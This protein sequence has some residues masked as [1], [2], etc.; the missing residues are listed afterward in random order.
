MSIKNKMTLNITVVTNRNIYQCADYRLF[1][2]V[3]GRVSDI[4][5]QKIF[6]VNAYRWN[7]TVCFTGV[8][9]TGQLNV[10][11]WLLGVLSDIHPRESFQHL[12]DQLLLADE[13]LSKIPSTERRH[14]FN[15][16]A[17]VGSK[18]MFVLISN[19]EQPSGIMSDFASSRLAV[20]KLRPN[21][22]KVYLS[23]QRHN[24][25]RSDKTRLIK[26]ALTEPDSEKM[27]DALA[28]V[29]RSVARRTPYVSAACFTSH[30]HLTGEGGGRVHGIVNA[31]FEIP[32]APYGE[33]IKEAITQNLD[34]HFGIGKYRFN[35]FIAIRGEASDEFHEVQ[36][37]EKPDNP[38]VHTNF[39]NY[40]LEKKKDILGAEREYRQAIELNSQYVNALGNLAN[41]LWQH[42]GKLDEAETLYQRA[43][44]EDPGN[45][46]VSWNYVRFL[47]RENSH[48][49][50]AY[51]IATQGIKK[52][53][54]SGRLYLLRGEL[55]LLANNPAEAL[56]DFIVA[57]EKQADQASVEA[58]YAFAL[59]MSG[60]SF[61]ECI[62]AY[63]TAII[64]NPQN[65]ELRLNLAQLLYLK[66]NNN[67]A[68]KLLQEALSLGIT[69][70]A[71]LEAQFYLL[72]HTEG[73]SESIFQRIRYLLDEGAR[74]RWDIQPNVE[75]VA[76]QNKV[77]GALLTFVSNVISGNQDQK[78]LDQVLTSWGDW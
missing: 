20:Y 28:E 75:M 61:D 13:W 43:I 42:K 39:G 34:E 16:G 54:D 57:R 21:K 59:H 7:A 9:R 18:P 5:T 32:V 55:S 35:S 4:E 1:D 78:V 30:V 44:R 45:E 10:S 41:L 26:L 76:G 46:N 47:I 12:I 49:Q 37:K 67:D 70:E 14:S 27:Y 33:L 22:E 24:V 11:H 25:T 36:L 77:K 74:L 48:I 19:F 53:R 2:L 50:E 23:G 29:N 64:L 31:A 6:F 3:A 40:L 71:E 56:K 69:E 66:N 51:E 52:N 17:F 62:G 65:G 15:V 73:K 68:G 63:R 38:E 8:G 72:C 60:A 58:G